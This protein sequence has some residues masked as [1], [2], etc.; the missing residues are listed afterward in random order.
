MKTQPGPNGK[1]GKWGASVARRPPNR[2]YLSLGSECDSLAAVVVRTYQ[3]PDDGGGMPGK[4]SPFTARVEPVSPPCP[5]LD[6]PKKG[7]GVVEAPGTAPGSATL[8]LS[9]VYRHSRRSGRRDIAFAER[10][11]EGGSAWR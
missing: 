6:L 11:I 8:I 4:S 1:S 10:G 2:A 9:C 5:P 7:I 3:W